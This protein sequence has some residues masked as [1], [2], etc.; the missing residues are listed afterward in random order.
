[1]HAL[2]SIPV[3]KWKGKGWI[4]D[5]APQDLF[6]EI[7]IPSMEREEEPRV[8][9]LEIK[10]REPNLV[11]CTITIST[12]NIG[13]LGEITWIIRGEFFH[14]VKGFFVFG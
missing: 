11:I 14:E 7:E 1:M 3:P 5:Q 4:I 10:V 8:V 2:R 13:L 6:I 9:D 12:M